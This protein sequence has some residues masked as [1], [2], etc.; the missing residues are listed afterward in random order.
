MPYEVRIR[1]NDSGE[2]RSYIDDGEWDET[3][4]YIW[5]EGNWQCDC[6][7]E[8]FFWIAGDDDDEPEPK[9]PGRCSN[10]RFTAIEAI[11][12]DGRRMPLDKD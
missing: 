6:N 2:V 1:K 7:R 4:H 8:H 5:T 9:G 10:G 12:A 11:L 3:G